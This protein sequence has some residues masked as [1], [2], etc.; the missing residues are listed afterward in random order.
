MA[1]PN[2]P[3]HTLSK[4]SASSFTANIACESNLNVD[5]YVRRSASSSEQYNLFSTR[6]G[7][8]SISV[9]GRT[10]YEY[11]QTY[12][13]TRDS[14]NNVSTPYFAS[15]DLNVPNS[16]LSA[17]RSKWL[18][19][20]ALVSL[21]KG[22]LFANEAPEGVEGKPLVMPYCILREQDTDFHFMMS[23]QYFQTSSIDFVVFAPGAALTETC[24]SL[25]RENYDWQYLPFVKPETY[26]IAMHPT[27]SSLTSENFRYKDGNLIFRGSVNYDI[28][29]NRIL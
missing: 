13:V 15:I 5:L 18:A 3:T 27:H 19:T 21:F 14:N 24:M 17:I 9:T 28:I 26:T 8:G 10:P 20:P 25:I 16:A 2:P 23:E 1:S 6:S 11:Y 12:T 7:P 29:I 4:T 22:G